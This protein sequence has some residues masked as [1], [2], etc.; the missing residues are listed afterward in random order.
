MQGVNFVYIGNI[1]EYWEKRDPFRVPY[2]LTLQQLW[3]ILKVSIQWCGMSTRDYQHMPLRIVARIG[4]CKI[5]PLVDTGSDFNAI[6]MDFSEALE[7]KHREDFIHRVKMSPV[8]AKG[9]GEKMSSSTCRVSR[10]KIHIEGSVTYQGQS[11]SHEYVLDL[12]EFKDLGDPMILGMPFCDD[13]GGLDTS[14]QNKRFIWLAGIFIP[15]VFSVFKDSQRVASVC[16]HNIPYNPV[17]SISGCQATPNVTIDNTAWYPIT[18]YWNTSD[19]GENLG[20]NQPYWLE[21]HSQA[22][23][24]LEVINTVVLPPTE[25]GWFAMDV[26]CKTVEGSIVLTANDVLCSLSACDNNCLAAMR[27]FRLAYVTR[28][29]EVADSLIAEDQLASS[30]EPAAGTACKFITG[31]DESEILDNMHTDVFNERPCDTMRSCRVIHT[32]HRVEHVQ[33]VSDSEPTISAAK[34]KLQN[35]VDEQARLFPELEKEIAARRER[36]NA[37]TRD[38]T[39]AAY[40]KEICQKVKE[41]NLCPDKYFDMLCEQVLKPFSDRFWDEGCPAPAIK[42]FKAHI[43]LKP[44]AQVKYRQ[45][46][47]L[48]KFDATRLAYLYEEAEA[49]GKV[50]RYQLGQ[51]PPR[52]CTPVF[53]VDK[54]GSLIGRKVGDYTMFNKATEDYYYPAPEADQVL[55]DACGKELHSVFDCVWGFEQIDVDEET[56]EICSTM[57]PF[58]I[59][60]SKKL[61]QGIKQGPAIYQHMQ[62]SAFKG[63]YKSNGDPLCHV[64]LTTLMLVTMISTNI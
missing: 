5:L 59:F 9:F 27:G 34:Y 43:D 16:A 6:D 64:F 36:L 55:M 48:S 54:K 40:K 50:E 1:A 7:S 12:S 57:T 26:L 24:N 17:Q 51:T 49:E 58:G 3:T 20:F 60:K 18:T 13:Y 56:A 41:N 21:K 4:K 46:Y 10:W 22:S 63:E 44:N 25:A 35:R 28:E 31:P 61:P 42:G 62:D 8:E 52:I 19:I 53:I 32:I 30:C 37:P 29:S 47:H 33:L 11:K 15:R 45:P 23:D 38:Q 14:V 2:A 39:S